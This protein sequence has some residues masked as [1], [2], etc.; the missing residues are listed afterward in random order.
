M[1]QKDIGILLREKNIKLQRYYFDQVV[2]LIGIQCIYRAPI[3]GKSW[4]G[5]GELNSYFQPP[6]VVGCLFEDHPTQK[7]LKK[8]GWVAEL[9]ENSSLID[10][11]YDLKDLQVGALFI[12]PSGLDHA[13]G[14]VFKVISIQNIAVYPSSITCEIA[15][16]YESTF[17]RQ[18][19]QHEDNN[20]NILM[21]GD[22]SNF[23]LLKEDSPYNKE[24]K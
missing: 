17:D 6:I 20:M 8:R 21:D 11:P 16:V 12:I 13:R 2:K 3:D 4:D 24:D 5:W 19:L 9:Q 1:E 15:P 22:N 23:R 18:Q 14:R 7:S 10:V